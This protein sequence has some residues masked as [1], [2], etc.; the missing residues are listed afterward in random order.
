MRMRIFIALLTGIVALSAPLAAQQ[1]G[2]PQREAGGAS[3]A[4]GQFVA[5]GGRLGQLRIACSQ[6][7][8]MDGLGDA[9]GAFPRLDGQSAWYL[10]KSLQ[11]YASGL[12]YSEVMTPV[13]LQLNDR[14]MQDVA[15]YY[16]SRTPDWQIASARADIGTL[17]RGG[18]IS[19]VGIPRQGVA[20]CQNCHGPDG[21]GM[22]P[23]YPVLAGQ[24]APYL[25]TQLQR[26]R[27][28]QRQGDPLGVMRAV[29]SQMSDEDIRAVSVYFENVL[30]YA[31]APP[32]QRQPGARPVGEEAAP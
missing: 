5:L 28:G 25:E 29:A 18:A 22:P 20:A 23:V 27:S 12:R 32:P 19:A 21:R 1:I 14:A 6:C 4:D 13:A 8:G 26:W 17:Q 7:H 9:S 31:T 30:R 16:A 24:Y 15:A 2:L 10:Y 3:R 11:D